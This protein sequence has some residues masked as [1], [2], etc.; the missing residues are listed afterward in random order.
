MTMMETGTTVTLIQVEDWWINRVWFHINRM[1]NNATGNKIFGYFP[2]KV[3]FLLFFPS[4]KS[5]L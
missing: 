3:M 5:N 4:H 2:P 1:Q